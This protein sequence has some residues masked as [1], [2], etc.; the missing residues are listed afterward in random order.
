MRKKLVN[1][2]ELYD[3]R[4]FTHAVAVEGDARIVFVSGQVSYDRDGIVVGEGD[5]GAQCEQVF[6]SLTHA[7]RNA[8][9]SWSD[10]IKINGYMVGMT[11]D[12]VMTYREVRS[13]FLDRTNMPASTLVG[14]DKL[15]HEDLLIEVEVVAAL[16]PS[17]P[18]APKKMPKKATRKR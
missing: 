11:P 1:P 9:A 13:R 3:P 18:A 14:I 4:F 2:N 17:K 8:G 7:L 16:A 6:K 15:I 10:V 12:N 5:M